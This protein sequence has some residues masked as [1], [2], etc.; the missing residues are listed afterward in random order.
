MPS[1]EDLSAHITS[2]E[3]QRWQAVK[4]AS[5]EG[6]LKLWSN[7]HGVD[8][9][10]NAGDDF[11]VRETVSLKT[12]YEAAVESLLQQYDDVSD[13]VLRPVG[14]LHIDPETGKKILLVKSE[15]S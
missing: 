14:Q 10:W 9:V 1:Q 2:Q 7:D 8:L 5:I 12:S 15:R 11:K 3:P 4:G 13:G 6:V